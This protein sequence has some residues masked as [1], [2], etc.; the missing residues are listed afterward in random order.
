MA[1]ASK[2]FSYRTDVGSNTHTEHGQ[3]GV[4]GDGTLE[5][6]EGH[7]VYED[8]QGD[9][10]VCL[11]GASISSPPN[12]TN[13]LGSGAD[14]HGTLL[15]KGGVPPAMYPLNTFYKEGD[16]L[17]ARQ[18]RAYTILEGAANIALPALPLYAVVLLRFDGP[19][20]RQA[21]LP[22]ITSG[23]D[24]Y[25]ITF[26]NQSTTLDLDGTNHLLTSPGGDR[27]GDDT[28]SSYQINRGQCV[29]LM[30]VSSTGSGPWSS[31]VGAPV[32]RW[33]VIAKASST[34]ATQSQGV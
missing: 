14:K 13:T 21:Q 26:V 8:I 9:H 28:L 15:Q 7:I 18:F 16:L 5:K 33:V 10:S 4:L 29:T 22:T 31:A 34:T 2:K 24:G 3:L 27:I 30:A 23:M 1:G 11:G 19:A 6:V 20:S 25:C 17:G 32:S 12:M